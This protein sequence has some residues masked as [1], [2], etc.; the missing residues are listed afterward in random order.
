MIH[1]FFLG[2][3]GRGSDVLKL[4]FNRLWKNMSGCLEKKIGLQIRIGSIETN[5]V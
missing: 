3:R 5:E 2:G 1:G 4:I